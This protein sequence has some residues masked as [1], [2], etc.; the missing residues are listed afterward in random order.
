MHSSKDIGCINNLDVGSD[1]CMDGYW[2][3]K[4]I[5]KYICPLNILK[6]GDIKM[7]PFVKVP[8]QMIFFIFVI[9]LG[10]MAMLSA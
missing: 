7:R 3:D 1:E 6:S 5:T 2:I 4:P 8:K 9:R 10:R